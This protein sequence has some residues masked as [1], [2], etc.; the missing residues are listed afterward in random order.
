MTWLFP[1]LLLIGFLTAHLYIHR[2]PKTFWEAMLSLYYRRIHLRGERPLDDDIATLVVSNHANAFI[3][4]FAVQ[5]A[6]GRPLIRTV[7]ADWLEHWLVRWFVRA[8]GAVPLARFKIDA[9]NQNRSSFQQLN[10][11]LDQGKWVIVFPEGISHNRSKLHPFKKGAAHLAK[12]YMESTGKPIQVIQV[13]LYYTDKSRIHSDIWV[14]IAQQKVYTHSESI[15]DLSME[16]DHWRQTIQ[17]VLPSK[18]R[19]HEQ[20]TLNWLNHSLQSISDHES[21]FIRDFKQW[22]RNSQALQFRSWLKL[23]GLDLTV[24][25][26]HRTMTSQLSRLLADILILIIGLPIALLG[27][28]IHLPI[29]LIHFALTRQHSAAEDKW[30]SSAYIIGIPL[31]LAFWVPV[32]AV[33]GTTIGLITLFSGIY[34]LYYWRH[35]GARNRALY[36]VFS[37]LSAPDTRQHVIALAKRTLFP[38]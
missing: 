4:P 36:T 27:L 22:Q 26:R 31:Y 23:T 16:V 21:P 33:A 20:K 1:L 2:L 24:L 25:N 8:V 10:Q 12:Q 34:A 15:D 11:A 6:L 37:C 28:A 38:L 9:N 29:A 18:L 13:G 7:R 35:W 14:N 17:E 30:A 19:R 5:V 3:D 32:S